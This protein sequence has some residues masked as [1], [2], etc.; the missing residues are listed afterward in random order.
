MH[1]AQALQ[2]QVQAMIGDQFVEAVDLDQPQAQR[3]FRVFQAGFEGPVEGVE[4]WN[5]KRGVEKGQ[6]VQTFDK[7]DVVE[8]NLDV[9][10][11]EFHQRH[12]GV[13]D[14]TVKLDHRGE[15]AV[16]PVADR[17]EQVVSRQHRLFQV[18]KR[19]QDLDDLLFGNV[20]DAPAGKMQEPACGANH[21][22]FKNAAFASPDADEALRAGVHQRG[23]LEQD[24]PGEHFQIG[25]PE[26]FPGA[27]DDH[28]QAFAA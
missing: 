16:R 17:E 21:L 7:R 20:A 23:D 12:F 22:T 18:G 27:L 10:A 24:A 11:V 13:R 4:I 28:F 14:R 1:L 15:L 8:G 19:A 3:R 2:C 25:R 6:F 9:S 5:L 26:Q